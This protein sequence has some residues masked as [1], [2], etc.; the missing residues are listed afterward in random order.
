LIVE[1]VDT[2]WASGDLLAERLLGGEV[3][4]HER[5]ERPDGL[6]DHGQVL[7][8]AHARGRAARCR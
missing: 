6:V 7:V 4:L 3:D 5:R 8:G 2:D 1:L